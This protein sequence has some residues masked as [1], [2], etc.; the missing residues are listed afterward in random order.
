MNTA[1][2]TGGNRGLGFECARTLAKMHDWRLIIACRN[3]QAA[4]AAIEA[5]R[6]QTGNAMIEAM[7]LNLASLE[8][9]N[10]FAKKVRAATLPPIHALICNAGIQVISATQY[11]Q[12]GF[13]I[14][15]GVNHLGHYLLVNRLL[16]C[17]DRAGRII[18]VSSGTHDPAQ[19]SGMPVPEFTNARLLAFPTNGEKEKTSTTG[20]RRYTTSKLANIYTSYELTRRLNERGL[21]GITVNAFDPGLMP[22]TGLARDYNP[23]A[24]FAWKFVLPIMTIF[25]PGINRVEDSGADLAYLATAPELS[26]VS[27]KYFMG[28][29]MVQ[30]SSESYNREK[31]LELWETSAELVGLA[32]PI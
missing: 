29:K 16:D 13:E 10:N 30:S 32:N 23:L 8:S 26:G 31:A 5:L 4:E 15:F 27:G 21:G 28:R 6:R 18:F 25:S 19:K 12:D 24:R 7:Q 1:I 20:R 11:T 17:M 14:T 3:P 2:I 9:V 22:G